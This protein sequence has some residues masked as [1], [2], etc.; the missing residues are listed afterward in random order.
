M[1]A[2]GYVHQLLPQLLVHKMPLL[3]KRQALGL[4]AFTQAEQS[5]CMLL[6][7]GSAASDVY[8]A[9]AAEQVK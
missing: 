5:G 2:A 3:L 4:Q 7:A 6:T 1:D 9:A 8:L